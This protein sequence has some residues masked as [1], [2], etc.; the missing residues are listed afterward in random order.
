MVNG[1]KRRKRRRP[2]KGSKAR[3]QSSQNPFI[4]QAVGAIIL[5]VL[6]IFLVPLGII[7]DTNIAIAICMLIL[8]GMFYLMFVSNPKPRKRRRKKG[9]KSKSNTTEPQFYTALPSTLGLTEI[10]EQ[11]PTPQVKLP[12]R[13]IRA[14]RRRRDFVTYPLSVG[15][16]AYSDSY[17]QVDKDTVLRLRSEMAPELQSLKLAGQRISSFPSSREASVMSKEAAPVA[18]EPM[19]A[20]AAPVAAE[21]MV[22]EAAP[23]AAEPMV[24]EAAPVVAETI[25]PVEAG[26]AQPATI[27]STADEE[28][29]EEM[30]F[31]MEWD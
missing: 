13:P 18:A 22:A 26:I 24:T 29:E 31:D 15:G 1:Q 28:E 3:R 7:P 9:K 5:I 27:Q 30:E 17:V 14:A 2:R 8:G 4:F 25:V 20:E 21:P 10:P 23:V 12:P 11:V 6:V 16:G 19:V